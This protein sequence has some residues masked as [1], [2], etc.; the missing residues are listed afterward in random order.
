MAPARLLPA[1]LPLLLASSL[2]SAC[3]TTAADFKNDAE[4]FIEENVGL[5]EA[6]GVDFVLA[7]CEEPTSQDVGTTFACTAQDDQNRTWEFVVEITD[8][9]E[10]EV[11]LARQP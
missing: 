3:F 11:N 7:A 4:D 8:S 2:L 9:N 10:Y 1:A 5:S 6:L